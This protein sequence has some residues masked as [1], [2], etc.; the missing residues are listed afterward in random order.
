MLPDLIRAA[1]S[2]TGVF[3]GLRR[4]FGLRVPNARLTVQSDGEIFIEPWPELKERGRTR[5]SVPDLRRSGKQ[6]EGRERAVPLC[7]RADYTLG[8]VGKDGP[9]KAAL[10]HR[11]Y[12]RDLK[13]AADTTQSPRLERAYAALSDP[14][15][16]KRAIA[17]AVFPATSPLDSASVVAVCDEEGPLFEDPDYIPYWQ[18][19]VSREIVEQDAPR[20]QCSCCGRDQQEVVDRL[21]SEVVLTGQKCQ[22]SSFNAAAFQ[23]YGKSQTRQASICVECA[24]KAPAVM[25]VMLQEGS[26]HS[27]LVY[28]HSP[29]SGPS[30]PMKCLTAIWWVEPPTRPTARAT[31]LLARLASVEANLPALVGLD[32]D[33]VTPVPDPRQIHKLLGTTMAGGDR[34]DTILDE[35]AFHVVLMAPNTG[36]LIVRDHLRQDITSLLASAKRFL[37]AARGYRY[38]DRERTIVRRPFG[39]ASLARLLHNRGAETPTLLRSLLRTAMCGEAPPAAVSQTAKAKLTRLLVKGERDDGIQDATMAALL[40]HLNYTDP[41]YRDMTE[42]QEIT[43]D[44][45]E[46][47]DSVAFLCGRLLAMMDVIQRASDPKVP[48]TSAEKIISL[49]ATFPGRTMRSLMK[50]TVAVYLTKLRDRS[51]GLAY[52]HN[53]AFNALAERIAL[54]G[55]VPEMLN[56]SEESEFMIGFLMQRSQSQNRAK[57]VRPHETEAAVAAK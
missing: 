50:R 35:V 37:L 26:G 31:D 32:V 9:E 5:V 47:L 8:L 49:A 51:P 34:R 19:Y 11:G 16:V 2:E 6:T 53:T 13:A 55:G 3:A 10:L 33:G 21:P 25:Q 14:H 44:M 41:R 42:A 39:S 45:V 52:I 22:I 46:A 15:K 20:Q 17:E 56:A 28:R 12:L 43:E 7:D 54:K 40:L 29:R 1:A 23:S 18:D 24:S 38:D 30:E 57:P 27:R 48:K 4:G 36:R